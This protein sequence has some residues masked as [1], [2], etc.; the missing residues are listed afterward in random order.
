MVLLDAM[1]LGI[2]IVATAVGGIPDV[3]SDAE[4]SLVPP[5]DPD[6]LGNAIAGTLASPARAHARAHAARDRLAR[7]FSGNAWLDEHERIYRM[8][9]TRRPR[10]RI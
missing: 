7:Q 5:E 10:R 1:A 2:P 4:A 8:A 6:A 9:M 3:L